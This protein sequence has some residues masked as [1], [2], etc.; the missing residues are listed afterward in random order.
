MMFSPL[1]LFAGNLPQKKTYNL[2]HSNATQARPIQQNSNI[3]T[4]DQVQLVYFG[5]GSENESNSAVQNS[6]LPKTGSHQAS[7]LKILNDPNI[8]ENQKTVDAIADE[9]KLTLTREQVKAAIKG[10]KAAGY[11]PPTETL[12]MKVT[13]ILDNSNI[14]DEG[15]TYENIIARLKHENPDIQWDTRKAQ[16]VQRYIDAYNNGEESSDSEY[17][18]DKPPEG[19]WEEDG[20]WRYPKRFKVEDVWKGLDTPDLSRNKKK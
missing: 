3:L 6:K 18:S 5:G 10:L 17:P 12:K 9:L 11:L 14:T 16:G 19:F 1:T 4:H 8:P 7:V 20:N 13:K 2:S 15:K